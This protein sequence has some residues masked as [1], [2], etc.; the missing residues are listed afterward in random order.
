M[1]KPR[2]PDVDK[3]SDERKK[4]EQIFLDSKG[5][6]KLVEIAEKLGL[7]A[8]KIRKWKSLDGWEAKLHPTANE[9]GK[10]KPVERSTDEK[11]SVPRKRG[12]PKGNRNSVGNR[13]N[14]NAVP[15]DVTKHGGYSAVYWDVLDDEEK[16][17]I[18][19]MPKDEEMLLLEQI[20][21]FSVRERRIMQAINKYRNTDSPV[22]VSFTNRSERKRAF[23]NEEEEKEY[24]RIVAEKVA[25][26]ERMPGRECQTFTQ[27]D[28]KDQIIARLESEL[29]NVQSKKTKAIEALAKLHIEKQKLAGDTAA[30]DVVKS[31]AEKVLKTR[32]G[33]DAE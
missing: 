6:M 21:L 8:N 14:P 15:P 17:L 32:R 30:N 7:P 31:W 18:E 9:K 5:N 19:D 2:S 29:S 28:N 11:G 16:G 1:P 12:A 22:A 13:G 33:S 10:K 23:E 26:G 27:T 4:A 3:R 24:N 20:Q 25:N